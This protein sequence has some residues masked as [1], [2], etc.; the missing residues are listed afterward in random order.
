MSA[1]RR[2]LSRRVWEHG[3]PKNFEK[4]K[5]LKWPFPV[6]LDQSLAHKPLSNDELKS[7]IHKEIG[8]VYC[9]K[10]VGGHLGSWGGI[11]I[12]ILSTTHRCVV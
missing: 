5:S 9:K 12:V 2:E 11:G 10:G 7:L 1:V 4:F 6:F 8:L 3:P